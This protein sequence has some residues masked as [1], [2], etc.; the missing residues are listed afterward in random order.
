MGHMNFNIQLLHANHFRCRLVCFLLFVITFLLSL[1]CSATLLITP[2]RVV[3]EDRTRTSQVTL[4]NKG[5]E[6]TTYRISFIRQNMTEDG[7]FVPVEKDQEG[8]YSD[9]MV[10]YSPRQVILEPGQSQIVRL[11]LRKPR[12]L[13]DGEYRSHMLLQA[14]PKTTKSDISKA[15]EKDSDEISVEITTIIGVS[16]PVIV[17]HG[18]LNT[19]LNLANAAYVKSTDSKIK[20]Y[21]ALDMKRT[22]NQS[23]YGDF[24]VT[25][26]DENGQS[27]V[28]GNVKGVAVYSP[29]SLRRFQIPVNTPASK[30][31]S[32]GR[33]HIT[34]SASGKD[35]ETGLIAATDLEL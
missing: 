20:S 35:E 6:T 18:K 11:M 21:V 29:N 23:T 30:E 16:L 28:V 9:K 26:I 4:V 33:F 14:L 1:N 24:R 27:V 7:K 31:Y 12:G 22:G 34:Y 13:A 2:S 15:V 19:E 5:T 17:R 32:K 8:M 10:R 25:Y 3:F